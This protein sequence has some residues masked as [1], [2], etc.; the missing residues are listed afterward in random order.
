MFQPNEILVL[1]G[2]SPDTT[3]HCTGKIVHTIPGSEDLHTPWA[4]TVIVETRN[5]TGEKLLPNANTEA[6]FFTENKSTDFT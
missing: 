2:L 4:D 6:G 3:F 1:K 5:K